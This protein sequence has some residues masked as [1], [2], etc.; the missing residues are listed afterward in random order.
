[1][2]TGMNETSHKY[3]QNCKNEKRRGRHHGT[4]RLINVSN[5]VANT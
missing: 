3:Q 4:Q 5:A 1:M 2:P